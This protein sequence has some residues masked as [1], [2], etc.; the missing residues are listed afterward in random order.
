MQQKQMSYSD[1]EL[2]RKNL[3]YC[4]TQSRTVMLVKAATGTMRAS[5]GFA[6]AFLLF[7]RNLYV[8]GHN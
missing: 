5:L 4:S 2:T 3:L 6:F 7:S 1:D 8:E